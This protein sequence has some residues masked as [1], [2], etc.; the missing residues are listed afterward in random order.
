MRRFLRNEFLIYFQA[1]TKGRQYRIANAYRGIGV[2]QTRLI[3]QVATSPYSFQLTLHIK[4][5]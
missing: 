3:H 4:E 1:Y 5:L 2:V